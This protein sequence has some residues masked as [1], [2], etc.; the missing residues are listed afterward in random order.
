MVLVSLS[1]SDRYKALIEDGLRG[2]GL[3]LREERF[4]GDVVCQLY[5]RR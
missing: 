1:M 3:R 2:T 4:F 5:E